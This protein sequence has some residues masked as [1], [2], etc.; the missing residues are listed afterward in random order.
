MGHL[1]HFAYSFGLSVECGM[2]QKTTDKT[3]Y[4]ILAYSHADKTV[5]GMTKATMEETQIA[6]EESH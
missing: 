2:L 5:V 1:N 4:L 6:S 3:G